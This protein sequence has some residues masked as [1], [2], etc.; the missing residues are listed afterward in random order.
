MVAALLTARRVSRLRSQEAMFAAAVESP[1]LGRRRT[2]V[3]SLFVLAGLNCGVVTAT[4]FDGK[5][6]DAMQTAGQA[7]IWAAVGLALFAPALVRG[8]VRVLAGPLRALGGTGGYLTVLNVRQRS[9]AQAGAVMPIVLFT[10]I[11][12]GTIYMQTIENGATAAAG[13]LKSEEQRTIETL[14][15]VVVGMIAVFAAIM[16]VNTV[17]STTAYRRREFGQQRLI[18][19]TPPQVLRMVGLESLVLVVTGVLAG[20]LA[21]LVTVLPYSYART[22]DWLPDT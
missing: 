14:N 19:S 4:V 3:A 21:S 8:T 15:F 9:Q 10:A 5:G 13:A 17:I 18:G 11:A 1:R 6:Y 16:L 20:S 2:V 22:G 7:G 12:T